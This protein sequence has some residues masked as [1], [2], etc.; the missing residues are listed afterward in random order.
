[1]VDIAA[2]LVYFSEIGAVAQVLE[3]ASP[4]TAVAQNNTVTYP[5]QFSVADNFF[6]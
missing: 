6:G 1:M 4:T 3:S 2:E 5:G